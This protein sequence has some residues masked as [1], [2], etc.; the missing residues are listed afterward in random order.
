LCNNDQVE[1]GAQSHV[2]HKP[3]EDLHE[4]LKNV[5]I[6]TT[7]PKTLSP[8][9]NEGVHPHVM[10]VN[11]VVFVFDLPAKP[12]VIHLDM[13]DSDADESLASV[14]GEL[15]VRFMLVVDVL[16]R[17]LHTDTHTHSGSLSV[18]SFSI[19][20]EENSRISI[21]DSRDSQGR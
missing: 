7:K 18:L 12:A 8:D 19:S 5:H 13:W 6:S 10:I 11:A 1:E 2:G 4:H 14:T 21:R 17:Y 20:F 15:K 9:W 3:L 16:E